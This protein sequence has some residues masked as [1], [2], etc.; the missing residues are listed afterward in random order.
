MNLKTGPDYGNIPMLI[1]H[2]WKGAFFMFR[3]ILCLLCAALIT[4]W[5]V[6]ACSESAAGTSSYDFDLTFHLNAE[7]FPELLRS[8]AEGY[9]SL[10]NRLGLR[11]TVSW[12]AVTQCADLEATLYYV[13]DASLSYPFRLY[14]S[15]SRVFFTSPLINNEILLLN[16]AALMEFSMK[17][18][19][20]LGVPL[21][22]VALLYPYTTTSAFE[23]LVKSW[24]DV[25]GTPWGSIWGL[26]S[27]GLY[28]TQEE[29][30]NAPTGV[31]PKIGDI[32]YVDQNGDG[33]IDGD[34]YVMIARNPRPELMYALQFDATWKGFDL[35]VQ[36]QGG[37]LCDKMLLGAWTN[38]TNDAT[39][40]TKPWYGNYDNAPLYL[41]EQSWRPD[42]TDATYPRLSANASSYRNN[43]RVS[44]FWKRNGAYLRLKNVSL[45]YTLPRSWT[46]VV[47]MESIR[48]FVSGT[49]LLTFT[50]FKYL[51]PE[52]PN[53]V[54]GYYP[55]QRTVTFGIDVNF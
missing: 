31:E 40:L 21:S 4:A 5:I 2:L 18:K 10:V 35:N 9:A 19:N 47:G 44:D 34:D 54:T 50:Q 27:D 43:Y 26:E 16:M 46:R 45:G 13:D 38:G 30:D 14:G 39:P 20:T 6:P 25:I 3:R 8:R 49:N 53:V 11:G 15:R 28:Q 17:A 33:R 55:Q 12:S 24:Q 22:Y 36:F 7:S 48:A 42:N 29:V 51:D 32:K 41:V 1:K 52:S 23:G 37:A